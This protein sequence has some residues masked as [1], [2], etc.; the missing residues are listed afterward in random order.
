MIINT[1]D[2]DI[3]RTVLRVIIIVILIISKAIDSIMLYFK[4]IG[5]N[6]RR[7]EN[8]DFAELNFIEKWSSSSDIKIGIRNHELI[9]LYEFALYWKSFFD[10]IIVV[11]TNSKYKNEMINYDNNVLQEIDW[12]TTVEIYQQSK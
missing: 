5:S 9:E 7:L 4:I 10:K 2:Y 8:R 11:G 12:I 6:R 3:N 1:D